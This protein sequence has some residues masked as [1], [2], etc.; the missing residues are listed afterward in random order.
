MNGLYIGAMGMMMNQQHINTHSNNIANSNTNGYKFD[1]MLS[2]VYEEKSAYKKSEGKRDYIG[3]LENMVINQGTF[4]DLK[5]GTYKVSENNLDLALTDVE[6][7]AT[8][9]FV[10]SKDGQELMT[11]SGEFHLNEEGV[12]K[13]FSGAFVLD[14][15]GEKITVPEGVEVA[16][17]EAG[18]LLSSE[19]G[20]LIARLQLV[21]LNGDQREFLEK[22]SDAS[23]TYNE[24][25]GG[26][27]AP[28]SGKVN[29]GML[30]TSNVDLSKEMVELMQSQRRF[31]ATQK[32]MLTF[33]KI[34][35]KEANQLM[36]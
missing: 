6:G 20:E 12:L 30:E 32:T 15:A 4:I 13:T 19:T 11:R 16:V 36:G 17:S 34:Y 10:T 29:K 31:Q 7:E 14:E 25:L 2:Q 18:E 35:E 27:L 21:S 5:S 23:F 1:T 28:F 8:S 9:F 26:E 22:R 33:D 24:V 3:Q